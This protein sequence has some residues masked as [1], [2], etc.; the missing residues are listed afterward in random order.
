MQPE[1][2]VTDGTQAFRGMVKRRK[3]LG[4]LVFAASF[5]AA[6]SVITFLPD[7]YSSSA[8]VLIE[9][10][11]IPDELVRST[12]T[13]GLDT[14][15]P[16]ITQEILSRSR[17]EALIDR[18]GLYSDLKKKAPVEAIID[19]MRSD[20]AVELQGG[21]GSK[22]T[23]A[24]TVGYRGRDPQ[25]V[26]LVA[27]TLA[28]FYIEENLKVRERQATGTT[29]F[30][31]AQLE[32]MKNRLDEQEKR[33]SAF[34]EEHIGQLPQQLDANLQT[35]EQLNTQL[36][37]NADNQIKVNDRLTLLEG[38]VAETEGVVGPGGVSTIAARLADRRRALADLQTRYS[39]KYPDVINLKAE[40]AALEQRLQ[41]GAADAPP[42]N[43]RGVTVA[44]P[45]LRRALLDAEAQARS[46]KV[47]AESLRRSIALYQQRVEIAPKWEQEF[48]ALSRDYE[49]TKEMYR[50]LLLRQQE[51]QLAES[52][53]QRQKGEQFRIIE[54]ALVPES[55]AA[56][57]RQRFLLLALALCLGLAAVVMTVVEQLDS[58]Y[59]TVGELRTRTGLP[60]VS[61]PPILSEGDVR[62]RR[63]RFG[64]VTGGAVLG[65]VAIVGGSYF[66]AR[67]NARLSAKLMKRTASVVR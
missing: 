60:V 33:V 43:T 46:L 16:T 65:I 21:R 38:Q 64:L 24:F 44:N 45:E 58:T 56:P 37:L 32:E 2:R 6:A 26:A 57:N 22:L 53:E 54:P 31:S 47:E 63:R 30:M 20:I 67:D 25:K 39:D 28:S 29:Q 62:L 55:P 4:V 42:A 50:S 36:R 59:H 61:I 35:L 48:Q 41:G 19:Q 10:Q 17:L 14:R 1:P 51:S 5:A 52:M 34:K 8:T 12:V 9:R 3:W 15:L 40:I 7:I 27:N 13:S 23:I 49:T 18:F 11:Q 66:V